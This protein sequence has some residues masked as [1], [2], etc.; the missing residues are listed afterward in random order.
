VLVQ[1]VVREQVAIRP[2]GECRLHT[3]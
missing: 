1:V 3:L 2:V